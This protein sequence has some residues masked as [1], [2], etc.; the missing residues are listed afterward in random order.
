VAGEAG[1]AAPTRAPRLLLAMVLLLSVFVQLTCLS[2][3]LVVAPLGSDAGEYFAYAWNL[4]RHQTFSR[5]PSWRDPQAPVVPD[6]LRAPGYPI[7]LLAL[8]TPEPSEDWALRFGL[9]QALLAVGSVLLTW[10]IGRQLLGA[11]LAA[12]PALLVAINPF[13][14]TAAIFLLT[15]TS[16]TFLL[17]ASVLLG[18][19]ALREG[20]HA[21][22]AL[23]AGLCLGACSL[24]R[25]TTQ[26]LP[27]LLL[28][29]AWLLPEWRRWRKPALLAFLAFGLAMA[30]WL[31]RNAGVPATA[32]G[33]SLMVNSIVHG[34]YPRFMYKDNPRSLGFPYRFDPGLE[35]KNS[36][37]GSAFR[38]IAAEA[39]EQPVRYAS[40]Y[41]LGKPY[42][43]L[44]LEDVQSRDFEIYELRHAPWYE[45]ARFVAMG[46][47]SR[48]LHWPLVLAA[49][50]AM[51]L[52]AWRPQRLRLP[53]GQLAAAAFIA[54][55][56]AYAIALHMV[57]APFPRYSIPF[58]PLL[59]VLA[60][61]AAQAAWRA[62]SE[63][64]P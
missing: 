8:G 5:A 43:F 6:K 54:I 58:R 13:I 26:F 14:A 41:L 30:P 56:I 28:A 27:P 46:M 11:T 49:L 37:L 10:L 3:T 51:L 35:A 57:A 23:A 63:A 61:V 42:Y 25:P 48:A 53:P 38:A 12:A 44:S 4:D 21:G 22:W 32:P 29:A 34:S 55:V 60:L 40:W 50:A 18:L 17:L 47:A 31:V 24:V 16:F 59:Y 52:L 1:A 33:Q 36:D 62:H 64:R 2:R 7:L 45:D 20:A 39:I 15:E 19:R 9:M